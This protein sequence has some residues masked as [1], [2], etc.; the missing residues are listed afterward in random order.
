MVGAVA[1]LSA[2]SVNDGRQVGEV[3]VQVN[4]L[5]VISADVPRIISLILL[6]NKYYCLINNMCFR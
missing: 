6:R 3:S 2:S 1:L 5:G 4:V